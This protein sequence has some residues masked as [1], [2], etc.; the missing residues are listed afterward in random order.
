MLA[1]NKEFGF[2]ER[3]FAEINT[4]KK[5]LFEK[6]EALGISPNWIPRKKVMD[7]FS[8]GSTQMGELE[9]SGQII[10]TKVGKRK[11]VHRDSI[12]KL[13]DSNIVNP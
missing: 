9:K 10:V 2:Q 11:F 4:I 6:P 5:M 8:Y 3:L 13:L 12:A 7:F 1:E